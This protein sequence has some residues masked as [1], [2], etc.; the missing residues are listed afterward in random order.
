MPSN[1]KK[2][3]ICYGEVLW[4]IFPNGARAGGAP[5]N[6]AYNLHRMGIHSKIISSIGV[7]ALGDQLLDMIKNWGIPTDTIQ[8]ND[9]YP[10]GTVIANID[11]HNDAHYEIIRPVAWDYIEEKETYKTQIEAADAFVF[12]SLVTRNDVSRNTLHDLLKYAKLKVFDINLRPP[13]ID[14]P[15]ILSLL[16][17]VDIVKMNKAELRQLLQWID[18]E[19]VSE[20]KSAKVLRDKFKLRA[21]IITKGS[22]GAAY[23]EGDTF[24]RTPAV[25]VEIKDTVGSGDSFLA[26][27]LSTY[28]GQP[29]STIEDAL[30]NATT[31][32]AFITNHEG[33]CPDYTKE[34]FEVFKAANTIEL[35]AI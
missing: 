19:Y 28:I 24:V 10:T 22:K 13:F 31:L 26:G 8:Q 6:V 7:D 11:E 16:E 32:G 17:K 2:T 23:L 21:I 4:D 5:F 12:G 9:Q 3:I 34:E 1:S 29:G 20:E 30:R 15:E 18:V 35:K 27:F 25:H 33:A 14:I